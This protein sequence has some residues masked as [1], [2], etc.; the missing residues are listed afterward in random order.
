[1]CIR[2]RYSIAMALLDAA[3]PLKVEVTATDI[4]GEVLSRGRAGRYSQIEINRG[5]PVAM[6]VKHFT[7]AGTKWELSEQVRSKVTFIQHNLLDAPPRRG[8][9]D[10]IFLRNV[11]I[12]LS[13][14]HISEPTRPY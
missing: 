1:M 14:I 6:L 9:F 5:L 12:Y 8:P 4:S 10:I 7:R 2:D 13:L 11:L 3:A